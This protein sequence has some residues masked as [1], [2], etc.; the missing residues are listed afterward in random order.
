[1]V[2]ASVVKN[3]E[4]L[5]TKPDLLEQMLN[6][7]ST[8]EGTSDITLP[9]ITSLDDIYETGVLCQ[10]R[11]FNDE[12]N[13]IMPYVLNLFPMK[14]ATLLGAVGSSEDVKPLV[15]VLAQELIEPVVLPSELDE[16]D[17]VNFKFLQKQYK[18][19][20]KIAPDER[21][22]QYLNALSRSFNQSNVQGF[23]H[24]LLTCVSMP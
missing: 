1:M 6:P 5:K 21:F 23:I 8:S 12:E 9:A 20:F 18:R 3:D 4:I 7:N 17:E 22:V 11:V 24:M 2:F 14:K 16:V 13:V 15:N 19:C 10:A